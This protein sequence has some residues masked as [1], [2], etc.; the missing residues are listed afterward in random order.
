MALKALTLRIDQDLY[1]EAKNVA[2]K[3][4]RSMN[5]FIEKLITEKIKENEQK[6]LLDEFS[7][8]GQSEE[9]TDIEIYFHAQKEVVFNEKP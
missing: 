4:H 7:L 3:E 2:R 6:L 5:A 9:D 1:E 8:V